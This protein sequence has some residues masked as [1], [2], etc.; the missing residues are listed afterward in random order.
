MQIAVT[1]QNRK[2]ITEHA[3][4]CRKFWIYDIEGSTI[5]EKHLVELPIE[6]SFHASHSL[7]EP[8]SGVTVLITASMGA[9][10]H[11]RLVSY[12]VQP[13][14][15]MEQN[16]DAAVAAFLGNKLEQ[17]VID[18]AHHCHDH[19]HDEHHG[20]GHGHGHGHH[21]KH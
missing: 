1:S 12:G 3:G 9:G 2:T 20:H 6:Q 7:A 8:L 15:T 11:Q 5:R 18:Q 16:P 21:H 13:V 4:K 14:I 19:D 17:V 10:L